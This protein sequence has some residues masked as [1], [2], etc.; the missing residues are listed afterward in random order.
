MFDITRNSKSFKL[1]INL[2]KCSSPNITIE[3]MANLWQTITEG[4][5]KR[6]KITITSV[7]ICKGK[8]VYCKDWGCADGE[9]VYIITGTLNIHLEPR[10][11]EW[12]EA[13]KGCAKILIE[14]LKCPN[15]FL[16]MCDTKLT[17]IENN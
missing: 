11:D 5:Y 14:K 6:N 4:Y 13:V 15:T 16:E 2:T 9:N 1:T 17:Y 8:N 3:E 7:T 10:V 12:M